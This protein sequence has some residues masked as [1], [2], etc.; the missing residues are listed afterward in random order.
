MAISPMMPLWTDAYLGDTHHL[1]TTEHGAYFLLLMTA[2]RSSDGMLPDDDERLCKYAK[3]TLDKWKKIRPVLEVFFVIKDGKWMQSRLMDEREAD[4]RFRK[5]QSHK[6]RARHLKN[7][8]SH[9]AAAQAGHMP[10]PSPSPSLEKD[11]TKVIS[12]KA[13]VVGARLSPEWKLPTEWG[14]WAEELGMT[15]DAIIRESEKF[16][17]FWVAKTGANA[18][19]ADWQATWRNWIRKHLEG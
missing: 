8:D 19:K 15:R 2:W 5:S 7:K 14:Q 1:N 6:A 13:K 10:P 12:K 16:R 9:S 11:I 17:D 3:L 18:T 4:L